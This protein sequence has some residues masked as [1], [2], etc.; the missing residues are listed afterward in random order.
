MSGRYAGNVRVICPGDD[1]RCTESTFYAVSTLADRKRIAAD[2]RERPWKCKRHHN[3]EQLL[4]PTNTERTHI[5]YAEK[6]K[7]FPDLTGLFWR[8]ESA[9]DV[10]S[11]YMFGPGFSAV[12]DDFPEG[13]RIVIT[14]RAEIP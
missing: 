14:V 9:D 3:P 7:R 8:E 12:A 5:L 2:Q 13:T 6:S 10:G 11:G 4:T 1:G